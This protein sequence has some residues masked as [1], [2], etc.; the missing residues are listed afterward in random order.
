MTDSF[1]GG[2]GACDAAG[3]EVGQV[4]ADRD[5]R[6][7][8][9]Y[10]RVDDIRDGKARVLPCTRAGVPMY[11]RGSRISLANLPRRYELVGSKQAGRGGGGGRS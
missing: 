7:A 9:R 10:V 8:G 11:G 5:A 4:Y 3:A 6:R 2:G 1:G